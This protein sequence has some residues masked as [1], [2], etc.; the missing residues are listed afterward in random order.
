MKSLIF[1]AAVCF[2]IGSYYYYAQRSPFQTLANLAAHGHAFTRLGA[3]IAREAYYYF[4]TNYAQEVEAARYELLRV[5]NV[6]RQVAGGV[7]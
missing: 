6:R 4:R 2:F 5:S 3:R 1:P 7:Q